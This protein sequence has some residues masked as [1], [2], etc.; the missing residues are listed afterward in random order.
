MTISKTKKGII[1]MTV[2]SVLWSTAGIFIKLIDWNP[3]A[4]AG[5]R[6]LVAAFVVLSYILISKTKFIISK[7]VILSALFISA[8]ALCFVCANKLTTAANAIVLQYS[9]PIYLLIVSALFFKQTPKKHD[10][11]TVLLTFIGILIFFI[12]G[13]GGGNLFGNIL[14]LI[15]GVTM[16]LMFAFVGECDG[17]EKLCSIFLSQCITAVIGISL[18]PFFTMPTFTTTS[19]LSI[20]FLGVVQLGIPY[21]LYGV[22]NSNCPAITCILIAAIE[23]ILNPI[24]VAIFGGEVPSPLAILGAVIVI[25]SITVNCVISNKNQET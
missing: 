3:F 23:P 25:A 1:Q 18:M 15:S 6:G 21:T 4:I 24:F 7:K 16:G 5:I 20:L 10:V 19:V 11:V 17:D 9:A 14:G 8:T 13:I 2:C 22:A 12:D